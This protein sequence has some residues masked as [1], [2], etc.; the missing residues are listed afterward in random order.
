MPALEYFVLT[1]LTIPV[2]MALRTRSVRSSQ[3]MSHQ[4]R[5]KSSLHLSPVARSRMTIVPA[6]FN[7]F[8]KSWIVAFEIWLSVVPAGRLERSKRM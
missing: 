2:T 3:S 6:L 4:L 5:A 7:V 1:S 8:T